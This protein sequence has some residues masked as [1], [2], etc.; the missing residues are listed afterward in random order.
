MMKGDRTTVY[1]AGPDICADQ[2][3]KAEGPPGIVGIARVDGRTKVLVK[4]LVPGDI[5]IIDHSDLDRVSADEADR[6]P[7]RRGR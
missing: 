5:A 2:A 7:G 3:G 4:R 1:S 6:Q